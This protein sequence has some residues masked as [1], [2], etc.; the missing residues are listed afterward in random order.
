MTRYDAQSL[1]HF[2]LN[3]VDTTLINGN[4]GKA[5]FPRYIAAVP[6]EVVSAGV[7]CD[8]LECHMSHLELAI[9]RFLLTGGIGS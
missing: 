7:N 1:A 3:L 8:V 4:G 5:I 6:T 9:N 2:F